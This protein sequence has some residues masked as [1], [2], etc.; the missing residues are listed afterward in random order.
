MT[1]PLWLSHLESWRERSGT[2]FFA[3]DLTI[4]RPCHVH[5]DGVVMTW[6]K[7]PLTFVHSTMCLCF[8]SFPFTLHGSYGFRVGCRSVL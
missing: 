4:L 5:Q 8:D 3:G 6:G 7:C 1:L 2:T